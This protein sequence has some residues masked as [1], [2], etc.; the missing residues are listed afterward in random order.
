MEIQGISNSN[1]IPAH[2]TK[3][4]QEIPKENIESSKKSDKLEISNEARILQSNESQKDLAAIQE[5]IQN[6]FYNSDEVINKTASAILKLMNV[7]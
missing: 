7:Q 2:E 3:N 6:N 1:Y 5:K 4:V